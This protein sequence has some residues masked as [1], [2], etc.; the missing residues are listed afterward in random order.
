MVDLMV[1]SPSGTPFLIDVKGLYKE[2]YWAV[3]EKPERLSLYY[4]FAFMPDDAPNQYFIA[5][6]CTVNHLVRSHIEEIR[7]ARLE[8]GHSIEKV[9]RFPG[10]RWTT[11]KDFRDRWGTLPS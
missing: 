4:I 9:E 10:I 5:D 7:A 1:V 3:S 2:N 11:M 8:K 6:Q